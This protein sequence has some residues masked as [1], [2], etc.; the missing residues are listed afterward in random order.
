MGGGEEKRVTVAP[1]AGSGAVILVY[2]M[3]VAEGRRKE[4]RRRGGGERR[5]R[6]ETKER[7]GFI[8]TGINTVLE[9]GRFREGRGREG[10][11]GAFKCHERSRRRQDREGRR[12]RKR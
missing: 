7:D 12:R 8:Y 5:Q 10:V 2:G 11:G 6:E 4:G 9:E 1:R 3:G